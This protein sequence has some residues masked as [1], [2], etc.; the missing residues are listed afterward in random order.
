MC[1]P[2]M[3]SNQG[4]F[5]FFYTLMVVAAIKCIQSPLTPIFAR[6]FPS[7]D[8]AMTERLEQTS[9]HLRNRKHVL[10]FYRVIKTRVDVLEN[11]KC[12][13]NTSRA[14]ASVHTAFPSFPKLSRGFLLN[15]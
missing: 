2:E 9:R 1:I 6:R 14:Q 7:R 10:Y 11:E 8:S 15:N 3:P 5:M 12:C 4:I 13:G